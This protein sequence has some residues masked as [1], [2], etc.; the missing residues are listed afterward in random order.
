VQVTE[1]LANVPTSIWAAVSGV[2]S[3]IGS[4][5]V[6]LATLRARNERDHEKLAK[7]AAASENAERALFRTTLLSD[8]AGLRLLV[9]EGDI[10]RNVM[11]ARIVALEE[12]LLIQRASNEIMQRWIA[13][14]RSQGN[15][16]LPDL[17]ASVM[18]PPPRSL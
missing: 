3:A 4:W 16:A 11:R 14:F 7:E 6:A 17:P 8:I 10:E 18:S 5:I 2:V 13:F 1:L 15:L 12:Q 9:K